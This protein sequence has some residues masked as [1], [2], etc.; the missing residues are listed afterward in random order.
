MHAHTRQNRHGHDNGN[1]TRGGRQAHTSGPG[2]RAI[3]ASSLTSKERLMPN[4]TEHTEGAWKATERHLRKTIVPRKTFAYSR[5][6]R[7]RLRHRL[8]PTG[9]TSAKTT[10][11]Q[12]Q[13]L[14]LNHTAVPAS[15]TAILLSSSTTLP[16]PTTN[17]AVAARPG[18]TCTFREHP[19]GLQVL[20]NVA[21][22]VGH[23]QQEQVLDGLINVPHSLRLDERMLLVAWVARGSR[24]LRKV[25]VYVRSTVVRPTDEPG[26]KHMRSYRAQ[27]HL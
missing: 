1:Q 27:I 9:R 7:N 8:Q 2:G 15:R 6:A 17:K 25:R 26:L 16:E 20:H 22:L 12:G 10:E 14:S 3:L 4:G 24:G 13:S 19:Q 21:A 11:I 23:Q 18:Y 5:Y